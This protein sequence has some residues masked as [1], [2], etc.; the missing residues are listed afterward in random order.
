MDAGEARP[1]HPTQPETV[2]EALGFLA[3]R[4]YGDAFELAVDGLGPAGS[5]Q[6]HASATAQVDYE[7]R[8]EGESDP[9]D[10]MIV[11]GVTCGGAAR[12]SI[13]SAYGPSAD[14]AHAAVLRALMR[15]P[16]G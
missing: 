5:E 13:V 6:R 4:G 2:T 15:P 12:G 11:L 10:E 3:E 14:P 7:F 9:G 16:A 8:F 1:Q